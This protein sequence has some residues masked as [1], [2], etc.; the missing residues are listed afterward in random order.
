MNMNEQ[1][2]QNQT[3][4][5]YHQ[6]NQANGQSQQNNQTVDQQLQNQISSQNED[7]QLNGQHHQENQATGHQNPINIQISRN[8]STSS[9]IQ[10]ST[11]SLSQSEQANQ[12]DQSNHSNQ[13]TK[14]VDIQKRTSAPSL[15][16]LKKDGKPLTIQKKDKL[17][18]PQKS[19]NIII[20]TRDGQQQPLPSQ[21]IRPSY[22]EPT[23]TITK[24]ENKDV[25]I[26]IKK[27]SYPIEIILNS[28]R[29][30]PDTRLP[31]SRGY[32]TLQNYLLEM[33]NDKNTKTQSYYPKGQKYKNLKN[34][35]L[36]AT[37]EKS[38][39]P[40]V[41]LKNVNMW[42]KNSDEA[43][44]MN[45]NQSFN[46]LTKDKI[47]QVL[48]ELIP[49]VNTTDREKLVADI[50]VS[51]ASIEKN[52]ASIYAEFVKELSNVNANLARDIIDYATGKLTDYALNPADEQNDYEYESS[53]GY[54]SFVAALI[55]N[56]KITDGEKYIRTIIDAIPDENINPILIEMLKNFVV[57]VGHS[58]IQ[59]IDRNMWNKLESLL[60]NKSIPSRVHYLI[61]DTLEI[62]NG[63]TSESESTQKV[64]ESSKSL[65]RNGFASFQ[66]D[67]TAI[68]SEV[69]NM[70]SDV[71]FEGSMILFPDIKD[72][73]NFT[74][75][76][77]FVLKKK[78]YKK[79]EIIEILQKYI[80]SFADQQLDVDCRHIWTNISMLLCQ[81][82]LQGVVNTTDA[83]QLHKQIYFEPGNTNPYDDWD[84]YSDLKF[85]IHD[86]YYFSESIE[87]PQGFHDQ[88]IIDALKMPQVILDPKVTEIKKVS[89][90][91]TVAALR[92]IFNRFKAENYHSI[93]DLSRWKGILKSL[94][95]KANKAIKQI[96][97]EEF[98]EYD[99]PFSEGE[100]INYI[101]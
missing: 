70:R 68:P 91:I 60:T 95:K 92:S 21:K 16:L 7:N 38:F 56:Q 24:K 54:T 89:R 75:Y 8:Q 6:Q 80:R 69:D 32:V 48:R 66:D 52:F 67:F 96:L 29:L 63:Q 9:N 46:R 74:Y 58:F 40:T 17:D 55:S 83:K 34:A 100:F 43:F 76:Q 23:V 45:V 19:V 50:F 30:L 35:T 82:I 20:P 72:I 27:D 98:I 81:M 101:K 53:L 26:K 84:V 13:A 39:Q 33:K 3:D 42:D 31:R 97:E 5:Q 79:I 10:I 62:I 78:G 12:S 18:A 44:K 85:F 77:C 65:V 59:N 61:V 22:S 15:L 37:N 2:N 99:L 47:S 57:S 41:M 4:D 14:N 73:Y 51:K 28:D 87:I 64:S 86:N 25:N 93:N 11:N 88:E 49:E 71:F 1:P 36:I 94:Y 90:L